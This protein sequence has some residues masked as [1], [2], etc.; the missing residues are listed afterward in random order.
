MTPEHVRLL[1]EYD[2]WANRRILDACATLTPEQFTRDLS[3]SFPSIRD[4]LVHITMG[5]WFWHERWQGRSPAAVPAIE[6]LPDV[7]AVRER[8]EKIETTVTAFV[9][10]RTAEDLECVLHYRTTESHP[11]SQPLWQTLQHL[12]NHG[13]YHRGQVTTMLRQ[14]GASAVATDLIA[15]YRE[16]NGGRS[17]E[18]LDPS[19]MRLLYDYNS[20]ANRRMLEACATLSGELFTRD[21]RSSFASVRDTAA[22]IYG[23][24]WLWLE[25]FHGRSP[26][27]LPTPADFPEL[28]TLR[29][30]WAELERNLLG[31]VAALS[32]AD[33][34][35]VYEFRTTRGVVYPSALW[36]ALQH[37]ANHGSYHRGQVATMLRQL[38]AKPNYTD[39][40]YFFRERAG[41]ALD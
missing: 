9:T 40:I 32:S 13:S 39:L 12:V 3:S 23:A 7:A 4:T 26:T 31:Y 8:W 27:A 2:A 28:A 35:K 15:F 25:R 22:H 34:A 11:N 24:E 33:L 36:Q 37:V 20:W 38:G 5:Q 17:A 30:R 21:L 10:T 16:R 41:Q 6:A 29:H 14:S 19:T 1:F 18:P